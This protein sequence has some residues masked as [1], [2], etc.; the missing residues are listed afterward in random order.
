MARIAKK[1]SARK[2]VRQ[3]TAKKSSRKAATKH[4]ATKKAARKTPA[5][6]R[7]NP[8]IA[9]NKAL[10]V[11]EKA[12]AAATKVLDRKV[13]ARNKAAAK[14]AKIEARQGMKSSAI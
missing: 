3:A 11:A 7:A 10:L 4:V 9:A 12:V 8:L 2:A 6:K 13:S 5:K 1:S 14:V